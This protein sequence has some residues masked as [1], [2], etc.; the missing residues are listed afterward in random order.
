[1]ARCQVYGIELEAGTETIW[2]SWVGMLGKKSRFATSV[3]CLMGPGSWVEVLEAG[4]VG[5]GAVNGSMER[6]QIDVECQRRKLDIHRIGGEFQGLYRWKLG[7]AMV[8]QAKD[9]AS[10]AAG[11]I[12]I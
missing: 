1:M 9:L 10:G 8:R 7:G 12:I 6:W 3:K 4:E 11:A 2:M 5:I